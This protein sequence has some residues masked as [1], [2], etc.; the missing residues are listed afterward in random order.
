M[1]RSICFV[2]TQ[3][4]PDIV[5]F[6]V[7]L[8]LFLCLSLASLYGGWFHISPGKLTRLWATEGQLQSLFQSKGIFRKNNAFEIYFLKI[9]QSKEG[10]GDKSGN[11]YNLSFKNT[12]LPLAWEC[13]HSG[14][15]M[16]FL[17]CRRHPITFTVL[18]NFLNTPAMAASKG[19]R[20][21]PSI[22]NSGCDQENTSLAR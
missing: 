11:R 12:I 1:Q 3:D 14:D 15:S 20:R 2:A 18:E 6:L 7:N 5:S 22:S 13:C 21:L 8:P 17:A 4:K 16:G 10:R 19:N 9:K